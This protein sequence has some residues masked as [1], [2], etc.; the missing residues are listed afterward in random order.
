MVFVLVCLPPLSPREPSAP[1]PAATGLHRRLLGSPRG[2]PASWFL[3][4][5]LAKINIFHFGADSEKMMIFH[6]LLRSLVILLLLRYLIFQKP[7]FRRLFRFGPPLGP[8]QKVDRSFL[9]SLGL[10]FGPRPRS[11]DLLGGR[12]GRRTRSRDPLGTFQKSLG[13]KNEN[14]NITLVLPSKF[15]P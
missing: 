14:V 6:F 8:Q 12:L 4:T 7:P 2:S 9:A 10:R 13:A 15:E 11:R 1:A 3:H 5:V